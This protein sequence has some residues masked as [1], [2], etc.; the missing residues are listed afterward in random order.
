MEAQRSSFRA[1]LIYRSAV[2]CKIHQFQFES[3]FFENES[4]NS[5]P[6]KCDSLW[7]EKARLS[8]LSALCCLYAD[9]DTAVAVQ[10]DGLRGADRAVSA[11]GGRHG[12]GGGRAAE[13]QRALEDHRQR[14]GAVPSQGEHTANPKALKP[15]KDA[16]YDYTLLAE[17]AQRGQS[18]VIQHVCSES[19]LLT[20]V[21][22][23][24]WLRVSSQEAA[25]DYLVR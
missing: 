21:E 6:R 22:L 9:P 25:D 18:C 12:A 3:F 8:I 10:R 20:L 14:D 15:V 24:G 19:K 5:Q 23:L 16:V 1:A 17:K 11:E 2:G 7:L 13:E 4:P